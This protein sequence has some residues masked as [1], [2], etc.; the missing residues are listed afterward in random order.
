MAQGQFHSLVHS[1]WKAG[2]SSCL[3]ELGHHE[4]ALELK[5]EIYHT[6]KELTP[7]CIDFVGAGLS[8]VIVLSKLKR[9][10]EAKS[11]LSEHLPLARRIAGPDHELILRLEFERAEAI[12]GVS[13][14]KFGGKI[15]AKDYRE[16]LNIVEDVHRRRLRVFG[17]DHPLTRSVVQT[18][19]SLRS[20][21]QIVN[22][23]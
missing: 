12:Y 13:Q 4:E 23:K 22:E 6:M 16:A 14:Q 20:H 5:K 19:N 17:A 9:H 11:F 8:V 1:V 3:D 18:L 21:R 7:N 10:A 2:L 15:G